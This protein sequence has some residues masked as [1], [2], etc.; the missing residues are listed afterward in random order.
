[1][2]KMDIIALYKDTTIKISD[3]RRYVVTARTRP[4]LLLFF[5]HFW[6][7]F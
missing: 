6:T 3:D 7:F 2:V 4:P 1:M 5:D